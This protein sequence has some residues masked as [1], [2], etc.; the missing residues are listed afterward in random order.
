[1]A[2]TYKKW[3]ARMSERSDMSSSLVHL[4]RPRKDDGKALSSVDVILKILKDNQI[5]GSSASE[6]FIH[7]GHSAVCFQDA[8]LYSIAQNIAFEREYRKENKSK[9]RYSGCGLIFSKYY[10]FERGC[11]PVVYDIPSQAKEYISPANWYRIVS[12]D[13]SDMGKVVDW[14]H[15][16]E[17]RIKGD[18]KFEVNCCALLLETKEDYREFI[19]KTSHDEFKEVLGKICGITVLNSLLM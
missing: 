10:L 3:K 9:L 14:S 11:R 13:I 17:W 5:N 8:P 4:T 16:R 19:D 6:G 12:L 18:L 7:G 2:Y 15:E 1:M